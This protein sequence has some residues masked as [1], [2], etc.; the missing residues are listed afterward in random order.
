MTS[1]HRADAVTAELHRTRDK[2]GILHTARISNFERVLSGK[3][4]DRKL[5]IIIRLFDCLQ[6]KKYAD[7]SLQSFLRI[8]SFT[9]ISVSSEDSGPA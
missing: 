8:P 4:K 9:Y 3:R 1:A 6:L 2:L 7:I 5:M